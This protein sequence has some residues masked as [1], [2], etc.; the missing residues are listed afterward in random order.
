MKTQISAYQLFATMLLF[1]YGS[2]SLFFLTPDAKQDAWLTILLYIPVG[3]IL[4]FLY[5]E[6]FYQYPDDTLITYL[7][8]IFGRLLGYPLSV[9][10]ILYFTYI[11]ARVLRDF[12]ELILMATMPELSLLLVAS[13][14]MTAF[15]YGA[16]A[17]IENISR[18]AQITLPIILFIFFLIMIALYATPEVVKF[19]NLK[20]VLENGIVSVMKAGLLLATF[21]Y[22]EPVTFSMIYRSVNEPDKV[23]KTAVLAIISLG[24]ILSMNTIMIIVTLGIN[25]ATTSQFPLYESMRLIK[26]GGIFDKLDILIIV[27]LSIVGSMKV[28]VFTYA[29]MLGTTQ[30]MKWNDPKYLAIPFG[31]G[32]LI[33]SILIAPNYPEHIRIGLKWTPVY[34]HLPLIIIVP[35]LALIVHYIKKALRSLN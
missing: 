17:G 22:G 12:S 3:I 28:C 24:A 4:Q 25:F 33:L 8:K 21:P 9:I 27:M 6:L 23:R 32:I 26:L 5:T 20:P 11:A 29:A 1:A 30:L 2:A 15:A 35:S 18:A 10:Y 13:V 34:I 31:I 14:F 16:F 7:P 19:R